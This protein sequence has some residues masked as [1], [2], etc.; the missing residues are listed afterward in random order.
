MGRALCVGLWLLLV[1]CTAQPPSRY[2]VEQDH[3]PAEAVDLSHLVDPVPRWEPPSRSGNRSPYQVLGRS[4][5]V[6]PSSAGFREQG[7]ASWYGNKFHGHQTSSGEVYDMYALSAAHKHLPLPS[8][9]RVTN[10]DNGRQVVVRVNDR[11]PFHAGR[12]IDLSYAAAY[13]LGMLQSGTAPVTLEAISPPP[14]AGASADVGLVLQ[15]GAYANWQ[16]AQSVKTRLARRLKD[17][18]I[19]ISTRDGPVP[20][21]RVRLGPLPVGSNRARIEAQLAAEGL[22]AQPVGE[23]DL[24]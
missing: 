23:V 9:V 20:L 4:Y 16:S 15:V 11:G 6:L 2:A 10:R 18:P 7:V 24:P 12:I 13:R 3:G 17:L 14:P 5:R 8:Y 21:Y 22:A 1:G 19:Q